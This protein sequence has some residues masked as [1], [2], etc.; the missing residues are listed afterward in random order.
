MIIL[1][2]SVVEVRPGWAYGRHADPAD[3]RSEKPV[4]AARNANA[5]I[6]RLRVGKRNRISR[7]HK[8][9]SPRRVICIVSESAFRNTGVRQIVSPTS[10]RTYLQ[11]EC[12][13]VLSVGK[14]KDS[15][16]WHIEE[17]FLKAKSC[18]VISIRKRWTLLD[19]SVSRVV[20]VGAGVEW[21]LPDTSLGTI[22]S[23]SIEVCRVNSDIR[24]G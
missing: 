16:E 22:V 2:V 23:I 7:A 9:T 18:V 1:I 20:A 8:H 10:W 12:S 11:A 24:A 13:N 19:A 21:T 4:R 3:I 6:I 15:V 17:A 5:S 14:L